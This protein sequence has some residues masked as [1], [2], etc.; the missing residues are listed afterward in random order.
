MGTKIGTT[1]PNSL[2]TCRGHPSDQ[3]TDSTVQCGNSAT[4]CSLRCIELESDQINLIFSEDSDTDSSDHSVENTSREDQLAKGKWVSQTLYPDMPSGENAR[5]KPTGK[6]GTP[7]G[8]MAQENSDEGTSGESN[9]RTGKHSIRERGLEAR[10]V[11]EDGGRSEIKN[12][13][14]ETSPLPND[15]QQPEATQCR[16]KSFHDGDIHGQPPPKRQ[17]VDHTST[18]APTD[19]SIATA[20]R[21]R[22]P[23]KLH[24]R[25]EI[26]LNTTGRTMILGTQ[27]YWTFHDICWTCS[28][29]HKQSEH[30]KGGFRNIDIKK[31]FSCQYIE[32]MHQN[33]TLF[34]GPS[35][36]WAPWPQTKDRWDYT[37]ILDNYPGYL[38]IRHVCGED[39]HIHF[40]GTEMSSKLA[41]KL[42]GLITDTA[43][44]LL[45][46]E[47]QGGA[48]MIKM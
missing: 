30:H 1:P 2:A 17:R 29:R 9:P 19:P 44:V 48:P 4:P 23:N 5:D 21:W 31:V 32:Q 7:S 3:P 15:I 38:S 43:N 20:I 45:I 12:G 14:K 27:E 34:F 33:L 25:D 18:L 37:L 28:E 46:Y 36:S 6:S 26:L 10:R 41:L 24:S 16:V 8:D 11:R 13:R 40:I 39:I 47:L 35:T 22:Q 42:L